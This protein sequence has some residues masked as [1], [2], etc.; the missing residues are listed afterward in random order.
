MPNAL[1]SPGDPWPARA[2]VLVLVL[3][4]PA[5][6][7]LLSGGYIWEDQQRLGS[8]LWERALSLGLLLATGVAYVVTNRR[9]APGWGGVFGLA[10]F[11]L[12]PMQVGSIAQVGGRLDLLP[13]LFVLC[14]LATYDS[15]WRRVLA[16]ALGLLG[17]AFSARRGLT[18]YGHDPLHV[19]SFQAEALL[20]PF[21]AAPGLNLIWPPPVPWWAPI[22][23]L[24]LLGVMLVLARDRALPAALI[25]LVGLLAGLVVREDGLVLAGPLGLA[26]A[27][28]S[29]GLGTALDHHR[30]ASLLLMPLVLGLFVGTARTASHWRSDEALARASLSAWPSPWSQTS[31]GLNEEAAGSLEEARRLYL[32]ATAPPRPEPR[33]CRRLAGLSLKRGHPEDTVTD[34]RGLLQQGCDAVP[35][36]LAPMAYAVAWLGEWD[37]AELEA[38]QVVGDTTGLAATVRLAAGA[39]RG[40]LGALRVWQKERPEQPPSLSAVVELL[41]RAGEDQ[42]ADWTVAQAARP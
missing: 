22:G 40:E 14:A 10:F 41:R 2:S 12:H 5:Y 6:L 38:M 11:M 15:G 23:L 20:W 32:L 35:E 42:H 36:V 25:L 30:P 13:P 28:L 16:V 37:Q 7:Q 1:P 24:L 18:L 3:V 9:M 39:R 27:G 34:G 29:L 17:L 31:V 33:A 4:V 21:R 8:P 26:L 19:L